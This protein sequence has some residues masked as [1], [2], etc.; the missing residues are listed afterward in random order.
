ML[1]KITLMGGVFADMVFFTM[2]V[3]LKVTPLP[4]GLNHTFL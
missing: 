3:K 1:A 4:V 2:G